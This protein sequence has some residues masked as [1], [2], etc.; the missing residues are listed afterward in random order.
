MKQ[1]SGEELLQE[2][3]SRLEVGEGFLEELAMARMA[4]ALQLLQ[5]APAGK[6]QSLLQAEAGGARRI[7]PRPRAGAALRARLFH[8]RFHRFALPAA[9]HE[10][11]YTA[12]FPERHTLVGRAKSDGGRRADFCYNF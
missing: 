12:P 1:A 9:G 7:L 8:L 3:Q 2:R 11:D 4:A 5:H 10:S 6:F